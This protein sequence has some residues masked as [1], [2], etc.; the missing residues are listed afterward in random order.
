MSAAKVCQKSHG[1]RQDF[2]MRLIILLL[3]M[4]AICGCVSQPVTLSKN[5]AKAYDAFLSQPV[6]ADTVFR[7]GD[8]LSF[9]LVAPQTKEKTQRIVVQLEASCSVPQLSAAYI[10]SPHGR[11]YTNRKEGEYVGV[12]PLLSSL[13][14]G[15]TKSPSFAQACSEITQADW[16]IVKKKVNDRWLML[17]R[18]SIKKQGSETLFWGAYDNNEVQMNAVRGFSPSQVREHYAVDCS[19]QTFRRLASYDV[20]IFN[21]VADGETPENPVTKIVA[22]ANDDNKLLFKTVCMSTE[23]LSELPV[24]SPRS[25]PL[26]VRAQNRIDASVLS[27]VDTINLQPA[28]KKLTYLALSEEPTSRDA[29]SVPYE[30][31]YFTS[32]LASG[33]LAVDLRGEVYQI[34]KV[35]WRGLINLDSKITTFQGKVGTYKLNSLSFSGDWQLMPIGSLLSYTAQGEIGRSDQHLK[36]GRVFTVECTVG[37]ELNASELNAKLSGTAKELG[38]I[39]KFEKSS[40]TYK[41]YYLAE[42]GYFLYLAGDG[43]AYSNNELRILSVH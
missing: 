39:T 31:L 7:E 41:V 16:R 25:K 33:Q 23:Q 8:R 27:A 38:C 20:D 6:V 28:T 11:F 36:V 42:Y 30:E 26:D 35:T 40:P 29:S 1:L 37:R 9:Q 12:Q 34:H 4:A 3:G 13:Y 21:S 24:Y 2:S 22:E 32:D 43:N 5:A 10:D 15:L 17:D 18:Q 19:K 14:S